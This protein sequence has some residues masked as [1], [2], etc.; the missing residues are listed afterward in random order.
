MQIQPRILLC[1]FQASISSVPV[2]H[3]YLG[4]QE[5]LQEIPLLPTITHS[6]KLL[7]LQ[8]LPD[9]LFLINCERKLGPTDVL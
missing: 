2:E 7:H 3:Q 5:I 4:R 9:P 8:L 1:T 6:P